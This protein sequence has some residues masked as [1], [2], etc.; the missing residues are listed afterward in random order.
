M[1]RAFGVQC[2]TLLLE[3]DLRDQLKQAGMSDSSID[4]KFQYARQRMS[5]L[6]C[7]DRAH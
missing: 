2:W 6:I 3:T 5:V 7:G 4:A 1:L